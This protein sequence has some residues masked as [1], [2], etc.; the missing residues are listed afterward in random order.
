MATRALEIVITGDPSSFSRASRQVER[1][2]KR[3]GDSVE[4]G[5]HR[6]RGF[7]SVSTRGFAAVR[8]GAAGM[9]A[10]AGGSA[11]LLA[12]KFVEGASDIHESLTKNQVLFGQYAKSVDRFSQTS[13][14]SFGISRQAA[15]EYTGVFGNLFRALGETQ[16][17]SA[18]MSVRLTRL[19]ADMASFNNASIQDTLEAI[20]S[21]IVGETEPLRRFGVNIQDVTLRQQAM[22]MGLTH[23]TKNVLTPHQ[24]ALAAVALITR[25]TAAAHGDFARTSGGLANQQRVLQ[26]QLSDTTAQ[27]GGKLMPAA[28]AGVRA[29]NSLFNSSTSGGRAVRRLGAFTQD[30]GRSIVNAYHAIVDAVQQFARRNRAD[31]QA[32][33]EAVRNY[34]RFVKAVI[35]DVI[36][37]VV[38]RVLPVFK[39]MVE[40]ILQ[41]LRGLIR[42]V[43]G[44]VNGD[45][46][47][48]WEGFK[49]IFKGAVH[50]IVADVKGLASLI[51]AGIKAIVPIAFNA[52]K[53]IGK[54]IINGIVAGVKALPG[55]IAGAVKGAVGG[56]LK[57]A[58][59]VLGIGDGVGKIVRSLRP[60]AIGGFP[61]SLHGANAA[62]SPFAAAG[63]RF[64]LQLTAGRDDHSTLT[65]SG[66]VSYHSTGEAIDMSNGYETP[67]EMAFFNFMA[68]NFGSRL[69]ELIYTPAGYSI[70]NGQ[71][72]APIAASDHH[73]HVHVALDLGKPGPGIGDGTGKRRRFTGD[74]FGVSQL[75]ALARRVGFSNPGLAAAVAMAESGGNTRAISPTND[76]GLWQINRQYHPQ[77]FQSPGAIFDPL[78]NARAALAISGG[79]R[80]WQPWTTF[81]TGAYRQYLSAG[82]AGSRPGPADSP[83]HARDP[84]TSASP[85]ARG[86][87][88]A[89]GIA[90]DPTGSMNINTPGRPTRVGLPDAFG[91][92][93]NLESSLSATNLAI[94]EAGPDVARANAARQRQRA[95]IVE[96]ITALRRALRKRRLSRGKRIQYQNE[97][98]DLIGAAR[99]IDADV[100]DST[101]APAGPDTTP[102]DTPA[103]LTEFDFSDLRIAQAALT[104]DPSDDL[105]AL[106]DRRQKVEAALGA[107][108]A[109]GDVPGQISLLG[110]LKGLNDSIKGLQDQMD[111]DAEA[112]R[113]E[114]E[115]RR[116]AE[117]AHTD[118]LNSVADELKR[119]NDIANAVASTSE[120][121]FRQAYVEQVTG[122]LGRLTQRRSVTPGG[123]SAFAY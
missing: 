46:R 14:R 116:A 65:T 10:A 59:S 20:R 71:R 41:V 4:K 7:A 107:A 44:V 39:G 94:T 38:R 8:L 50:A 64:G 56:A 121:Q 36:I 113:Q 26:A 2:A 79:G 19:A 61:S 60:A 35:E 109:A 29:L 9:A 31:I 87:I 52:A 97:L 84:R 115:A 16:R 72:V 17:H 18:G 23:T 43:T 54:G 96:R 101:P 82:G 89:T 110:E 15:L 74:G 47:R 93:G 33:V 42:I 67:Q 81:R 32:V 68:S 3:M 120:Y 98:A 100:A 27:L 75:Q 30:A 76:Y 88:G 108:A 92:A 105:S 99:Q 122:M 85:V 86:R 111:Q 103:P 90:F 5:G 95:A 117:Q 63:A 83:R 22:A 106:G 66:N 55:A 119:S 69:A 102:A 34:G 51:G 48:V 6:I 49:D 57:G 11:A 53:A 13:A 12:K 78:Y 118:A 77:Y 80:N 58:G 70:K 28:L 114:E 62:L 91:S 104:D 37:P 1:D 45:W 123:G 21:G 73:D 40:G 25:Q 24:R 112:R